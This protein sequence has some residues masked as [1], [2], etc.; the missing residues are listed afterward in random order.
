MLHPPGCARSRAWL[1]RPVVLGPLALSFFVWAL[2]RGGLLIYL[3]L[4]PSGNRDG[5]GTNLTAGSGDPCSPVNLPLPR[6]SVREGR[7]RA[8]PR[9]A[10]LHRL[11]LAGSDAWSVESTGPTGARLDE[12]KWSLVS[13]GAARRSSQRT[14]G[15]ARNTTRSSGLLR[16]RS[17]PRDPVRHR[18]QDAHRF[19][20]RCRL[21]KGLE[22]L[23]HRG[24]TRAHRSAISARA[25]R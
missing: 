3:L 2:P 17:S 11:R 23:P 10:P 24:K 15:V 25:V 9:P 18:S 21:L 20:S 5:F 22:A 19:V 13:R 4:A 7:G 16:R 6:C 1:R 14:H 8:T 12:Q